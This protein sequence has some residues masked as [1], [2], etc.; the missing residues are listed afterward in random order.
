MIAGHNRALGIDKGEPQTMPAAVID[1][2]NRGLFASHVILAPFRHRHHH[3]GQGHPLC[4]QPIGMAQA[5]ALFL[6]GAAFQDPGGDKLVQPIRQH[7]PRRAGIGQ[8]IRI[9]QDA[10]ERLAQDQE[11]PSVAQNFGRLGHWADGGGNW[12]AAAERGWI[13]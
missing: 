8:N 4:R 3:M 11:R 7:R 13:I 5:R 12:R 10:I 6:I 1:Q 2:R 9:A